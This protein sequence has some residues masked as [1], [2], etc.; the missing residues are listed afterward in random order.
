M[1]GGAGPSKLP[2]KACMF[3]R[4]CLISHWRCWVLMSGASVRHCFLCSSYWE[5]PYTSETKVSGRK[6]IF[7]INKFADL[8]KPQRKTKAEMG[9]LPFYKTL[10]CE[11]LYHANH[12]FTVVS[13]FNLQFLKLFKVL[14][15]IFKNPP[16]T[17]NVFWE[18]G[19]RSS[20]LEY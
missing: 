4:Y 19:Q 6:W 16:D 15:L 11:K 10:F 2:V 14:N 5:K 13:L 3:D 20:I 7:I 8:C 9:S 18:G 12:V 1:F 17:L